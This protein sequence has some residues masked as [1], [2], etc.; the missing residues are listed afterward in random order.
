MQVS[1]DGKWSTIATKVQP[2]ITDPGF[3]KSSVEIYQ[4]RLGRVRQTHSGPMGTKEVLRQRPQS[5]VKFNGV[6]STDREVA[7]AAALVADAYTVFL[8]G[9]SWLAENG[10]D[11]RLLGEQA[12]DGKPCQLVGGRLSPGLGNSSEDYFIVWIAKESG[13]M[14]RFQF[15][16]NGMDSTRGADVDVAFSEF[17]KAADGSVWPTRFIERIQRPIPVRA[18]D[19]RMTSLTLDGKSVR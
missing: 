14:K 3:R 16:L 1:Y 15:S 11:L 19:W 4:P 18:H 7:D 2:V 6:R 5:D 10:R 9:T 13:L 12:L 8:F 17:W